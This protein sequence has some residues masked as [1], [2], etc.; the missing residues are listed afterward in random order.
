MAGRFR[1]DLMYRLN[2]VTIK[3]PPLRERVDDIPLLAAHFARRSAPSPVRFSSEA[4]SVLTRYYWPGNV[5]E[6]ENAVLHAVSMADDVI[7]PEHLPERVR[8]SLGSATE[9]DGG[10]DTLDGLNGAASTYPTLAEMEVRYVTRV[11][12]STK[13]NKQAAAKILDID[14]KT[15]SRIV[16]R[17]GDVE[18]S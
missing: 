14:R 5:R 13:G 4:L 10:T 12:Q 11:L 17:G 2:A 1:Q 18:A 9:S 8:V 7:Y 3:L 15:L 16:A 6:L